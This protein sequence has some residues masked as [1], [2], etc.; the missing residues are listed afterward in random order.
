[1]PF[2]DMTLSLKSELRPR[3]LV[4]CLLA[5]SVLPVL[6]AT[7]QAVSETTAASQQQIAQWLPENTPIA[8]F[9]TT[10]AA[11][12]QA[13]EQFEL[14]AKIAEFTG[15]AVSP[16]SLPIFLPGFDYASEVQPWIG[17]QVVVTV[18]PDTTPRSIAVTDVA[19]TTLTVVP[20]A[21]RQALSPFLEHL[22]TA[23]S[24]EVPEKS[25]YEGVAL[26]VWPTRTESYDDCY[27]DGCYEDD[28]EVP[29]SLPEPTMA[30]PELGA[31]KAISPP[32]PQRLP[33]PGE[34]AEG[35]Y[36]Y[37]I[38][39]LAVAIS[40]DYLIFAGEPAALK[41]FIDY[42]QVAGPILGDSDLF[43]RSQYTDSE[44]AI[45]R[46]YANLSETVKFNLDGGLS[47]FNSPL[48][49]L[50][51]PLPGLP[52]L[53]P[54]MTLPLEARSLTARAL[55]GV[56]ID[57]LIYPQAEGIRLQGRLYG[58][59]L[60]RSVATPELP[61]ADSALSFVPAPAYSLNSGRDLAGLWRQI[62]ASLSLSEPTREFLQQARST[63]STFLGLDLDTE[64]LGWMDKEIVLFFFPNAG[65]GSF[66]PE[67]NLETGIA[68]QTSDRATAQKALDALDTFVGSSDGAAP[69]LSVTPTEINGL[70]AVSWQIPAYP[71]SPQ[72]LSVFAHS[73]IAEDTVVLTSGTRAMAQLL[74]VANFQSVERYPTF[75]D[76]TGSLPHPNNGYSYL[77][78]GS[79][80]SLVYSL[81]S[82]WL[83][84]P[85][86]DPFFQTVKSFLGTIRSFGSTTSSTRDYWQ[87]DSLMNLAPVQAGQPLAAPMAEPVTV[88]PVIVE[89][90]VEP[91]AE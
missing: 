81:L 41:T 76:A 31:A 84:V 7:A 66:Q 87:L 51:T 52:E 24:E 62:A 3:R 18:L 22:E 46:F 35:G 60:V 58:N 44:G 91:T 77:N 72:P 90:A 89:P 48:P 36:T 56:T 8:F 63:V 39:G 69:L 13:L 29:E 64:L 88:E 9:M 5:L 67:F 80:L 1:M 30:P 53:I 6:P 54:Q 59:D 78:A 65:G 40:D 33:V 50:P 12:W 37:Q 70:P 15:G 43:L 32:T 42:Q 26:W 11:D 79:T 2:G 20:I 27:K 23:R 4:A 28:Y 83:A 55:Q 16:F 49:E 45:A 10:Q 21:N 68:I 17:D 34:S 25:T 47:G 71:G 74:N 86:N 73:W 19:A 82:S 61:E 14:F 85:P 57:S 75:L 38:P